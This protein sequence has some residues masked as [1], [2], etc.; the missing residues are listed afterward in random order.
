LFTIPGVIEVLFSIS[1]PIAFTAWLIKRFKLSWRT[2]WIGI[3]T[4]L[5][6]QIIV[7]LALEGLSASVKV[8][9][10]RYS[11]T[12]VWII[13]AC[14]IGLVAS[15][16]MESL[17]WIGFCW[18]KEAGKPYFAAFTMAAGAG[19]VDIVGSGVVTLLVMTVIALTCGKPNGV[20]YNLPLVNYTLTLQS[21]GAQNA[22][23]SL[24]ADIL[25]YLALLPQTLVTPT[26][27]LA[28]SV[29]VWMAIRLHRSIWFLYALL[30]H[31][32]IYGAY[33]FFTGFGYIPWVLPNLSRA[34]NQLT[35]VAGALIV[36]N[37]GFVA[38]SYR[39]VMSDSASTASLEP[40]QTESLPGAEAGMD[41]RGS[42]GM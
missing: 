32:L 34:G 12:T 10:L 24:L 23:G 6:A 38:W 28:L 1:L 15:L 11:P 33:V 16:V 27:Y 31:L 19:F 17:R 3:G 39:R 29:M 9:K 26:M 22:G 41:D 8:D 20:S 7:N 42:G 18:A 2:F 4:G 21:C 40:L 25:G 5:A 35:F 36:F 13:A 30:W 14:I 37:V